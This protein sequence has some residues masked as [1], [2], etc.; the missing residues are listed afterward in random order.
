MPYSSQSHTANNDTT[1]SYSNIS[2]LTDV[3]AKDQLKVY[4][5][6]AL[7]T[8][9]TTGIGDY[10]LNTTAENVIFNANVS[11]GAVV[12]IARSTD[13]VNKEVTFTNS[14]VLTAQD[15][16]KS[17]DQLLFLAQEL[18]DKAQ[19]IS[20]TAVG[21]IPAN[22]IGENKLNQTSGTE[23]VV[24]TAIRDEAVTTAKIANSAVT[25]AKLGTSAVET[26]KINDGAVT[27]VKI[28]N[29][30]I[31]PGKLSTG[32]PTWTTGGNVTVTGDAAV[33]GVMSFDSGYGST[34]PVYGCRA[35]AHV[36]ALPVTGLSYTR[37]DTTVTITWNSHGLS[38]GMG[39]YIDFTAGTPSPALD[40]YYTVTVTGT[41]TFTVTT[42]ATGS[43]TGGT[44]TISLAVRGSGNIS[45]IVPSGTF[46]GGTDGHYIVTFSTAMPDANYCVV[47]SC[48][49]QGSTSQNL[50]QPF[51]SASG[52]PEA[53]LAGSFKVYVSNGSS[54][55]A[56]TPNFMT[57]AVFR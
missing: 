15:L 41:N 4:V 20:L 31:E 55:N 14:S 56:Y 16:N 42:A 36:R 26:A 2:L 24:T 32:A 7:K 35:W 19:D 18:Y 44:C 52:T 13:I 6:G 30:T 39:V 10:T 34:A 29:T 11:T 49:W 40:G 28:A 43:I 25:S 12:K 3:P 50:I 33:D 51:Q 57:L 53:P 47:A 38:S 9:G 22:S 21:E 45:S 54:G 27:N 48:T 5:N 46:S 37:T 1:F 8:F 17:T 23:A